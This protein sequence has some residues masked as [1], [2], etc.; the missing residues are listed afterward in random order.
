MVSHHEPCYPLCFSL[1]YMDGWIKLHRKALDSYI[2]H[3]EKTLKIWIWCLLKANHKKGF[4]SMNTGGGHKTLEV[5]RG[6]FI[7]GRNVGAKETRFKPTT[8]WRH[9]ELL[10]ESENIVLKSDKL[11]TTITVCNY[12]KYQLTEKESGQAADQLRTNCGPTADTN[13]KEE[14]VNN[15]KKLNAFEIFWNLYDKK[16]DRKKCI[17]HWLRLAEKEINECLEKTPAY[18]KATPD[19]QFRK[20]PKTFLYNKS[21]NNEIIVRG[22]KEDSFNHHF[23]ESQANYEL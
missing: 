7:T 6:Q 5:E 16:I 18:I 2:W 15:E 22:K 20:D 3:N 12:D 1:L 4:V 23:D 17:T 13:K 11:W 10:S 9:L 21:W 14:N 8:F 19:Q